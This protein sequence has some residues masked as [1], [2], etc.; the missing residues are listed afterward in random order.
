MNLNQMLDQSAGRL[1]GKTA[2]VWLEGKDKTERSLSFRELRKRVLQAA[3]AFAA[4]GVGK[5]DCVAIVHRNGPEFVVAYFGLLRLGAIAVPINYMIQKPEELAYM[6]NH[7]EAKGVV[8]QREFLRGLLKAKAEVPTLGL[9]LSSDGAPASAEGVDDFGAF[10]DGAEPYEGSVDSSPEDT[11]TMLFTSGTT[12]HPKAVMLT[13]ANLVSNVDSSIDAMGLNEDDVSL[14]ILPMFHTFAWTACTLIPLRLGAKNVSIS[15]VAPPKPWLGMMARHGVTIFAAVPQI[16]SLLAKQAVGLKKYVLR[17]WFFRKVRVAV[18]GAAPLGPQTLKEFKA[19]FGVSI[20]EGY[21]LTETSPVATFNPLEAPKVGS[22]GKP[23]ADVEVRIVGDDGSVLETGGE[24][25]IEIKG[26]NIMKGYYKNEQ[27]TTE[28][29]NA[30]GWFKSGDVGL[31]DEDGYLFIKDRKKDMIIVKGLKVFSAQVEKTLSTHPDI[32]EAAVIGIPD[33]T[34]DERIKAFIVL[35]EG[36]TAD[37]SELHKF[38]RKNL[39]AY[40]RPRDIEILDELPKNALQKTLK[41]VLRQRELEKV[42]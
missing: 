11:V 39:D 40:K 27:A 1:P 28:A 9:I 12:G 35:S 8:A 10:V 30:E 23:I 24:G 4:R 34:G 5:G 36:A 7:V 6:L 2:L 20:T 22:V 19:G 41:R 26:P 16:Y 14:T 13:H 15:A 32:Q 38:C 33:E 17:W 29:I 31:I 18:S 42:K 25:E 37:T 3:A 21:G